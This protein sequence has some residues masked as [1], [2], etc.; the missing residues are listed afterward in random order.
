MIKPERLRK[1][2]TIAVVALS[3]NGNEIFPHV[4]DKGIQRL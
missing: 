3:W 2:D 4:L 1:G